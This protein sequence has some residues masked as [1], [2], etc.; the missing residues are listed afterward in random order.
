MKKETTPLEYGWMAKAVYA[1]LDNP[2]TAQKDDAHQKLLKKGWRLVRFVPA[3]AEEGDYQGAVYLHEDRQEVVV[4]HAGTA[5]TRWGTLEADWEAVVNNQL[6]RQITHALDKT[7]TPAGCVSLRENH[8][9]LTF[10]GH[11]LGGFLAAL[12][13]YICQ[14]RDLGYHFPTSRAVIFDPAGSQDVM[15]TLEPHGLGG[16]GLGE[17]GIANLDIV[18]FLSP[19][20]YVNA[21]R[22]HA[23]GTMY[24]VTSAEMKAAIRP[25]ENNIIGY[26]KQTHMLDNLLLAFDPKMGYPYPGNCRIVTDWP[27]MN[28]ANLKELLTADG[29]VAFLWEMGTSLIGKLTGASP[30]QVSAWR[31][32]FGGEEFQRA[33]LAAVRGKYATDLRSLLQSRVIYR[34]GNYDRVL[35]LCHFPSA[36][37]DFLSE[38]VSLSPNSSLLEE[39]FTQHGLT[40]EERQWFSDLKIEDS[41]LELPQE[42]PMTVFALRA[43]LRDLAVRKGPEIFGL[44]QF[45]KERQGI[46]RL[47]HP[48]ITLPNYYL[49]TAYESQMS[50]QL[51]AQTTPIKRLAVTGV[52]G[53]GKT[54]LAHHYLKNYQAQYPHHLTAIVLADTPDAWWQSLQDLAEALKPGLTARLKEEKNAK[55]LVVKTLQAALRQKQWC[56]LVDNLEA[57]AVKLS[58][59]EDTLYVGQ[60]TLLITSLQDEIFAESLCSLNLSRGFSPQESQLLLKKVLQPLGELPH[61]GSNKEQQAL[62]RAVNHLPLALVQSGSYL[63][64]ENKIRRKRGD[65]PLTYSDYTQLLEERVDVLIKRHEQLLQNKPG[66]PHD[67]NDAR[68]KLIKTQEAAVDLSIQKAIGLNGKSPDIYLWKMLCFCSFLESDHIPQSLLKSYV[69]CLLPDSASVETLERC[70]HSLLEAAEC[71]SLLLLENERSIIDNKFSLNMHR[72]IQR[73]LRDNYWPKLLEN[74]I[75]PPSQKNL[76]ITELLLRVP[77]MAALMGSFPIIEESQSFLKIKAYLLH[78]KAWENIWYKYAYIDSSDNR[79]VILRNITDC[80]LQKSLADACLHLGDYTEAKRMYEQVLRTLV[81]LPSVEQIDIANVQTGLTSALFNLGNYQEAKLLSEQALKTLIGYYGE[82][83]IDVAKAQQNLAAILV[84]LGYYQEAKL[85]AEQAL[86]TL[87]D[88]Y[89]ETHIDVTKAQQNLAATLGHLGDYQEAKL[90]SEQVLKTLIDYY[91]ETHRDVAQAQQNLAIGLGRLG[92]HQEAKLLS[93]QALKTLIDYYGETHIVVTFSQQNLAGILAL[94]GNYQEAKL[95]SEQVLKTLIGYYGETHINVAK[96]QQNLAEVLAQLGDYQEAK[97]LSEQALKTSIDY[98]GENHIDAAKAQQNLA[99]TLAQLG[100]YQEAKQLYEQALKIL[101]GLYGENHIDVAKVQQSLAASLARLGDYTEAE[102]LL[103]KALDTLIWHYGT[104]ECEEV[105]KTQEF[106]NFLIELEKKEHSTFLEMETSLR[107]I[108]VTQISLYG[109]NHPAVAST[110]Y[111]LAV[112]LGSLGRNLVEAESLCREALDTTIAHYHETHKEVIAI[113][114]NL[115]GIVMKQNRFSDAQNLYEQAL[116]KMKAYHGANAES[117]ED[118]IALREVLKDLVNIQKASKGLIELP[119]HDSK[120]APKKDSTSKKAHYSTQSNA[121][122]VTTPCNLKVLP[123]TLGSFKS[124]LRFQTVHLPTSLGIFQKTIHREKIP[125]SPWLRV[126]QR[127]NICCS[128]KP[129]GI[130]SIG[131]TAGIAGLAFFASRNIN[132]LFSRPNLTSPDQTTK[133]SR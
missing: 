93:E 23:G 108:L 65:L 11:S 50:A 89:G 53:S 58:E 67:A 26:L 122:M 116:K 68:F 70:F 118:V 25:M 48:A 36:M 28:L 18:H 29:Q 12:S 43:V 8:Y 102:Q 75:I 21:F 121:R 19:P 14:R 3:L 77:M 22:P 79:L 83:H 109:T 96:A 87:I 33:A 104:E 10:T 78:V 63:L 99:E 35:R 49:N 76:L 91:G 62:M 124:P 101:T 120:G 46:R 2:A 112:I 114:L 100:N 15:R 31:A 71:Y 42:A 59:L 1:Q 119:H 92:D 128:S 107:Q 103:K 39:F 32:P 123:V 131:F 94:L 106:L 80:N 81:D 37:A 69:H 4:A 47:P 110:Q 44:G 84:H 16:N 52:T 113:Q 90:L 111:H 7:L 98:Y 115:A 9:Q 6:H 60:G 125:I 55:A 132:S 5:F 40:S 13:L 133:S 74:T 45:I 105:K 127:K 95:L 57:Q 51:Q 97:L 129:A 86:K 17:S 73:V 38:V 85:L 130:A 54:L 117:H 41:Y 56:L 27:L 88:Y 82:S 34:E 20:N 64:W 126:L 24:A 30:E 61:L 72:V 66:I